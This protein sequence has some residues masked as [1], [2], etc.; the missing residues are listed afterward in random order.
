MDDVTVIIPVYGDVERW[1]PLARR[2]A[3]SAIAQTVPAAQVVL[4]T[5]AD[6]AEARNGPASWAR[7]EWLVFL[8]A[9]DELDVRYIEAM[10]AGE[11]DLRQPATLGVTDGVEDAQP[12]VI[13]AKDLMTGNYIVI[14]AMVRTDLFHEV[15]GFRS[16]DA[17][18]DWDLWLRV[19]LAGGRITSVP[20]AVYR[21][22]V[23]T[24]GRNAL[25]RPHALAAYHQVRSC[26][27]GCAPRVR[28]TS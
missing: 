12:V 4:A 8:D 13:P 17:Y 1:A 25:S 7:T 22:T 20:E 11:G 18:E 24:T 27:A 5:A 26:Y 15:G 21:V 6:L 10:L 3:A 14:G 16:L 19:W 2:A 9:D 28:S 23:N